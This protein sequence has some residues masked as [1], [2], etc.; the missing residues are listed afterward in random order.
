MIIVKLV[1]GLGNQLFQYALGRHISHKNKLPFK[2]DVSHY[3]DI[4]SRKYGLHKFNIKEE[5]ASLNE[6]KKIKNHSENSSYLYLEKPFN[7]HPEILNIK[8]SAYLEGY[9]QSEKYF[10]EIGEIILHDFT[11]K[12]SLDNQNKQFAEKIKNTNSISLHIRRGD[13]VSKPDTNKIHGT[14]SLDYYK[15]SIDLITKNFK[16][17]HFFVFSDDYKWVKSNLLV[18]HDTTFAEHNNDDKNYIDLT[19]MS[20]CKHNIIA[21]SSFSWWGAWLNQN[22]NKIVCSPKNWFKTNEINTIDLIPDDWN[23]VENIHI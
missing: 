16:N 8:E 21:N 10:K 1:E 9:W 15:K 17:P 22:P 11:L 3:L 7:F 4:N 23:K 6:I 20:M 2:L 19:L 5:F 13:Y 18:E 14:C 12:E